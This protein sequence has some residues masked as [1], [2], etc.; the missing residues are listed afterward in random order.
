VRDLPGVRVVDVDGP[1]AVLELADAA[2][3]RRVLETAVPRG[4]LEF[5]EIVPSL[6]DVYRE[7]T[8]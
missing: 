5:A 1:A 4:L 8:R 6:S 7:V 2:A 3:R